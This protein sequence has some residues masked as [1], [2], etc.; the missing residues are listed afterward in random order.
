MA[1][2]LSQKY[3]SKVEGFRSRGANYR[4]TPKVLLLSAWWHSLNIQ[5][6]SYIGMGRVTAQRVR[7][8]HHSSIFQDSSLTV[9]KIFVLC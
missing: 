8:N 4:Y 6:F 5:L 7:Q 2:S 3:Q 9:F 1:I